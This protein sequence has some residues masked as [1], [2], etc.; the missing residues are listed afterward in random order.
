MRVTS[1]PQ[2]A[3]CEH[4]TAST[5]THRYRRHTNNTHARVIVIMHVD[6]LEVAINAHLPD[7]L[8]R[9]DLEKSTVKTLQ[10][11]LESKLLMSLDT[12]KNYIRD[13][14]RGD[15]CGACVRGVRR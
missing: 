3:S 13:Q 14:V 1:H 12:K 10:K 2:C 7:I 6:N 5:Y 8:R 9:A 4:A 15:G 11:E